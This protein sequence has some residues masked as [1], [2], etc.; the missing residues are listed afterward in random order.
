MRPI[1]SRESCVIPNAL[2]VEA[3]DRIRNDVMLTFACL[4]WLEL[5]EVPGTVGAIGSRQDDPHGL[6]NECILWLAANGWVSTHHDKGPE[7][8][9]L[10]LLDPETESAWLEEIAR[11]QAKAEVA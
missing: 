4:Q 7:P 9:Y 2:F 3:P 10:I 8:Y 11:Q 6:I 1:I 5:D